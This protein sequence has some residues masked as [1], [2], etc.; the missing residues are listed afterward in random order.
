MPSVS[1]YGYT[2]TLHSALFHRFYGTCTR[3]RGLP[4]SGVASACADDRVIQLCALLVVYLRR[5]R[6]IELQANDCECGVPGNAT[7]SMG[8]FPSRT[9]TYGTE[10]PRMYSRGNHHSSAE[11]C[12]LQTL[13]TH[14]CHLIGYHVAAARAM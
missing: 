10:H 5:V 3:P 7:L 2:G 14:A 12:R 6:G 4:G 9:C 11:R 1:T 8:C 13:S